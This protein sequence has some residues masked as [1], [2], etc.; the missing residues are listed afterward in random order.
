M[1][2]CADIFGSGMRPS[3]SNPRV[4]AAMAGP[5]GLVALCAVNAVVLILTARRLV[6]ARRD[7]RKRKARIAELNL[8][9]YKPATPRCAVGGLY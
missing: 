2:G 9:G 8:S 3:R 4:R 7:A 6:G 1:L 5:A